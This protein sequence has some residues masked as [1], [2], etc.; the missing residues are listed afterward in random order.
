MGRGLLLGMTTQGVPAAVYFAE[1]RSPP[2]RQRK[3]MRYPD[4]QGIHVDVNSETSV[5]EL[6][7]KGGIPK[8][9]LYDAMLACGDLLIVSNGF[10][11]DY[12]PI[13]KGDGREAEDLV[14][15]TPGGISTRLAAARETGKLSGVDR[16]Q[17]I[18]SSIYQS[19]MLSGS[20][21][22][23]LRTARIAGVIDADCQNG[24]YFGIVV[25]PR[26]PDGSMVRR[27]R[28]ANISKLFESGEFVMIA[29]YGIHDPP[30]D[31]ALPPDVSLPRDYT[32]SV[33]L[34]GTSPEQL[35]E[36]VWEGLPQDILVGVASGVRNQA[37]PKGFEFAR[38]N[39]QE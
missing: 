3:L 25:R 18:H 5:E 14:D 36:E 38:R 1:G 6:I 15:T 7:E 20:E 24:G 37:E 34:D 13:W 27:D 35:V 9:L 21:V 28:V 32:R 4:G 11:T 26:N 22:D 17:V 19:L 10:Q 2:S 12:D 39:M 8:L 30:H 31:A 29:T 23:G 33:R 16:G